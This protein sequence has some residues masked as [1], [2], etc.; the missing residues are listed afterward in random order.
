M[1]SAQPCRGASRPS[2]VAAK[3]V[4][5]SV[6]DYLLIESGFTVV[7]WLMVRPLT[8]LAPRGAERLQG[9]HA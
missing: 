4:V 2:S 7:Q 9:E 5:T 8:A 1:G 3:N 6:P